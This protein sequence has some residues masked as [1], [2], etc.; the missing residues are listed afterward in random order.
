MANKIL[1]VFRC[2][3]CGLTVEVTAPGATPVCCGE[4]MKHCAEN[5]V[6]AA[7]E[8]HVPV[9]ED[10]NPGTRVKVGSVA[11]PMTE[12]HY[13]QWIEVINGS[14]VNRRYLKPGDA[15]E[16]EFYVPY[17]DKLVIRAYC[18]LHGLWKK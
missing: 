8:K 4:P 13:I 18:N 1:D 7:R 2:S 9:A 3:H 17:S 5:S 12:E 14:Y 16:A 6:D 10:L 15:P 11:H